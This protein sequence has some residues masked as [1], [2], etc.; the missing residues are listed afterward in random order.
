MQISL[1]DVFEHLI[2]L[3]SDEMKSKLSPRIRFMVKDV[4]EVIIIPQSILN[5]AD[6]NTVSNYTLCTT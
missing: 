1:D 3:V 6:S 4:I 2:Y 5:Q